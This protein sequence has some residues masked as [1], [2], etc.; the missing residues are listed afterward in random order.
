MYKYY[1][2]PII[3]FVPLLIIQLTLN[4]LFTIESIVPDLIT[5]L[6]VVLAVRRGQIQGTIYGFIFGLLH[7][8]F[9][10]GLIG[11]AMFSKTIAGFIAGYFYSEGTERS[12]RLDVKFIGIVFLCASIDSFFYSLLGTAELSSGIQYFLFDYSIFPG[13][14]TALVSFPLAGVKH[15]RIPV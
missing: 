9:T 7:D 14:Y 6:L 4:P 13:L 2:L 8:I 12:S 11:S 10:G 3:I 5:I 1:A 15:S